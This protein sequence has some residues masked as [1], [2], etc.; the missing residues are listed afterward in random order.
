[1]T[2]GELMNFEEWQKRSHAFNDLAVRIGADKTRSLENLCRLAY[3]SG[4]RAERK[5]R[6]T[7]DEAASRISRVE[8]N[9][10]AF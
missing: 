9:K 6:E 3:S 10:G 4:A 5:K 2:A 1:M 7:P 8:R